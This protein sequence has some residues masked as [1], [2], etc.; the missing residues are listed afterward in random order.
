VAGSSGAAVLGGG[1]CAAA[2]SAGGGSPGR[3]PKTRTFFRWDCSDVRASEEVCVVGDCGE[4]GD[5]DPASGLRLAPHENEPSFWQSAGVS[6]PM[7]K[8][9]QYKYVIRESGGGDVRWESQEANR[10]VVPTGRRQVIEDDGGRFRHLACLPGEQ[11]G[12]AAAEAGCDLSPVSVTSQTAVRIQSFQRR[13]KRQEEIQVSTNDDVIVVFRSLPVRLERDEDGWRVEQNADTLVFKVVSLLQESLKAGSAAGKEIASIRFVG[14]PGVRVSDPDER[15]QITELLAKHSCVPVFVDQQEA[16]QHLDFCH[17]FLW[18]V[19]HN[20]KVFEDDRTPQEG[21][22]CVHQIDEANW[23]Q[24]QQFNRTYTEVVEAKMTPHT[25]V[26]VHDF[27]LL[28]VPRYLTLRRQNATVGFFLHSAFPSSEVLRCIPMREEILQSLLRCKV[29]TFQIFEYARHFLSGCQFLLNASYSFRSGGV[30]FVEHEGRSVVLRA[31]HFVLPFESFKARLNNGVVQDQAQAIRQQFGQR[32]IFASIDGDE[33]FSGMILKLR[34]FQRLLTECPQHVAHVALLQHVLA[35]RIDNGADSELVQELKRMANETNRTFSQGEPLVVIAEGDL[36]VDGR[37]GVLQAA[38]V[39]LDTS[40]NDGLNVNP[41]MFCCT[42]SLDMRG[43]MIV[44]EFSGSASVLTGAVKV[45]PW[46]T[47]MVMNAM[48]TVLTREKAEQDVHFRKDYSYVST[49]SL[50]QWV[51]NNLAEMKQAITFKEDAPVSGLGAG[52]Q[53][54]FMERGF[55]HLSFEAVVCSYREA[56]T[57]AIFLDN[58]GTLAPDRRSVLLPPSAQE[59]VTR[60]ALPLDPNVLESLKL[61]VNDGAN[62]VVVISGRNSSVLHRQFSAV[63]GI[64]LCAE[65]GFYWKMPGKLEQ[66]S[67][68]AEDRWHCMKESSDEDD[69]WKTVA[70]ELLKQYAKRVQ[71]SNVEYKGSAITW[72]YRKVGAQLLCMEMAT[73]LMRFLDPEGPDSLLHGYPVLVRHGKGY[74]EVRRKDVDKGV[75]VNRVLTE[76][77]NQVGQIDFILCIGDDRSDEDM[78]EVVNTI[79]ENKPPEDDF[80]D[81]MSPKIRRPTNMDAPRITNKTNVSMTFEEFDPTKSLNRSKFYTVTVGRKPST[82]GFFLKDPGEVSELLQRLASQAIVTKLSRF[83]S[84]P[85]LTNKDG[86][87]DSDDSS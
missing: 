63:E 5:W 83:T 17:R 32:T 74:V 56:K 38:D 73:E 77:R 1:P 59:Q 31:D 80:P 20:M 34:A 14:D 19:M 70:F 60:E 27:Y 2:M 33:P 30:L 85:T 67:A 48:H 41:F 7:G 49:Q 15:R 47:Q 50:S 23:K 35:R 18:P 86:D 51:S 40:I 44:S 64:G 12:E 54:F 22:D 68:G 6:L 58:E 8:A 13:L 82:A 45:N 25:L 4:L 65:H 3:Q 87:V 81:P 55:R 76:L 66:K 26:W 39:L 21:S 16:E 28:L 72:N 36:S 10:A 43:S 57:R 71:G 9:V 52:A 37:L 84:M 24:Y 79:P 75:A 42:H 78:F 69:D 29:V 11:Q 61:L 53:L 46:D 62:T